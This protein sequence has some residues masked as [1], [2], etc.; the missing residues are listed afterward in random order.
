MQESRTFIIGISGGS[1]SGKT[2]FARALCRVL[3]ESACVILGQDSYYIDQSQRFDEDGGRVNFDHPSALDFDLMSRHLA[4]LR[5]G[6]TVQ[7]PVYDFKTH[8]RAAESHALRPSKILLVDGILLLSQAHVRRY[9]DESVFLD[10]P[11]QIRFER[12]LK[13]DVY[14]R[15]RTSEGV[16]AQFYKQVKPMH[17]RFVEPSKSFAGRLIRNQDEF[18]ATL[19]LLKSKASAFWPQGN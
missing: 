9:F 18:E 4:L 8:Q 11:E 14:E 16:R 12:R 1:G 19:D 2:T 10:I 17:D 13:R 15:G 6:L 5:R 3:G 7:V